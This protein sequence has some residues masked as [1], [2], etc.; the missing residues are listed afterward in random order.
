[1]QL[2]GDIGNCREY[3]VADHF[4]AAVGAHEGDHDVK[5]DVL[6]CYEYQVYVGT[7]FYG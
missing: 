7:P 3:Q 5:D 6:T 4:V 2:G 1:M